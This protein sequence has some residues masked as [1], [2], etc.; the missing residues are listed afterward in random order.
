MKI[1]PALY[2]FV[3]Q[4]KDVS[5]VFLAAIQLSF[6]TAALIVPATHMGGTSP[7]LSSL[8]SHNL[9][10]KLGSHLSFLYGINTLGAVAGKA[11]AGFYLLRFYSLST[12]LGVAFFL[13]FSSAFPLFCCNGMDNFLRSRR[14]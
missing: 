14:V 13:I 4:G 1:Y 8:F 2:I 7:V 12:T 11:S 3:A 6:A 10:G 9:P 5:P